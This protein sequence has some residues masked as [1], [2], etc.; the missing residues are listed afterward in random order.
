MEGVI[1]V[2]PQQS[3]STSGST[4]QQTP[5]LGLGIF[6]RAGLNG[7]LLST[8]GTTV[9]GAA[10]WQDG[11]NGTLSPK[12][13]QES[14]EGRRGAAVILGGWGDVRVVFDGR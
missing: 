3:T 11:A 6:E 2:R 5:I 7:T 14:A 4:G 12:A 13:V 8:S 1:S 10:Y 9:T